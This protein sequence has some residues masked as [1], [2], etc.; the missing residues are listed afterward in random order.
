MRQRKLVIGLLVMLALVVSSFTYAYWASSV[1]GNTDDATASVTI[2]S[3]NAVTTTVSVADLG[4][5]EDVLLVPS[6]FENNTTTFDEVEFTFNVNWT[7]TG[8]TGAVGTLAVTNVFSM[9]G[10][11]VEQLNAMFT[12]EIVSGA[13]S[14]TAGTAQE[15]TV[16]VIFAN[17]P[18]NQAIYA[19][20]AAGT[21]NLTVTFTVT[22]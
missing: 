18:A 8:A 2:G 17:Q 12:F 5:A 16:R 20:V 10:L 3:G 22:V 14:I 9:T 1:T 13:G 6:T 11:T 15:V 4:L 21:L 19:L 7:G